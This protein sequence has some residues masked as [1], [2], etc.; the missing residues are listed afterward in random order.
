MQ[1]DDF[2]TQID[3]AD[4]LLPA[5]VI[6]GYVTALA[7]APHIIPPEEWI[8]QL[9]G[10]NEPPFVDAAALESFC[11]AVVDEWNNNRQA[12]LEQTWRWP[13]GCTLDE[14]EIVSQGVRDYCEGLL[15][16]WHLV[17]DDWET[18]IPAE[19]EESALLGG[20]V[21]SISM[22]YDPETALTT[23]ADY[24]AEGLQ[25]FEEIYNA[26]PQMLCGLALR[27]YN[28]AQES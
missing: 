23:L 4:Q 2:Y 13:D 20:V 27:G 26:M 16:A 3:N 25:Q 9:W 21:L 22:L 5:D 1:L 24:G 10:G 17:K 7:A 11:Q 14:A 19:S 12:L 6:R 18:L 15:Q 8:A 28:L